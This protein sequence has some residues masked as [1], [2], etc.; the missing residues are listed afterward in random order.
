MVN[1]SKL[2]ND[3]DFTF[4]SVRIFLESMSDFHIHSVQL[5]IETLCY[6]PFFKQ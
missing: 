6:I 2:Q 5:K 3:H 1:I 4:D